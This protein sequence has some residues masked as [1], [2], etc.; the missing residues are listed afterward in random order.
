MSIVLIGPPAAGKSTVGKALADALGRDFVDADAACPPLYAEVGWTI[1]RLQELANDV[2]YEQAHLAWEDALAHA[3]ERTI[4]LFPHAVIALGAG[5]SHLTQ[6]HLFA[7]VTRALT[8]E[9]VVSIR[10]AIDVETSVSVL[11]QRCIA[12]KGHDWMRDGI[13]WLHRW[14]SDGRDESLANESVHNAGQ[15]VNQSVDRILLG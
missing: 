13:D 10:P 8:T 7:R 6:D 14:C 5:H 3:V 4:T 11:R 15:T 1:D 9:R 12:S 2:G